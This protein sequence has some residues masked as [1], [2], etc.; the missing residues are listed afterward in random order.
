LVSVRS[1]NSRSVDSSRPAG[2]STFSRN[3]EFS[4]SVTVSWRAARFSRD[5][6]TRMA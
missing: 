1:V 2:S 4:T 5:S 3:S 6:H